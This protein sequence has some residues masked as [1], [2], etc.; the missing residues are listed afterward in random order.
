MEMLRRSTEEPVVRERSGG[1][2]AASSEWGG[3][4]NVDS[5]ST[6]LVVA[7]TTILRGE[8]PVA[9]GS[10]SSSSV[11]WNPSGSDSSASRWSP[12]ATA[13]SPNEALLYQSRQERFSRRRPFSR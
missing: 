12:G 10:L 11:V 3:L 2:A 6:A 8:L 9:S 1:R 13:P 5:D 4:R 7:R